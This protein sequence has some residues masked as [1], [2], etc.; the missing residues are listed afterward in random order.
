MDCLTMSDPYKDPKKEFDEMR[1]RQPMQTSQVSIH[2][3]FKQPDEIGKM[4]IEITNF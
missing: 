2:T 4:D 3:D 1:Q